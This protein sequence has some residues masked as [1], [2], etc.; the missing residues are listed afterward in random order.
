MVTVPETRQHA[1]PYQ[2]WL[3]VGKDGN[4]HSGGCACVA[5]DG[6]C[7]HCTVLLFALS[8]FIERHKERHTQVGTDVSC[9]WDKPRTSSCPV[10]I[11]DM[12]TSNSE[13]IELDV[14]QG[15]CHTVYNP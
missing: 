10:K 12:K 7:K 11:E 9:A 15:P 4:I 3:L 6:F 1:T 2:T 13:A 14:Q 8:S 5:D